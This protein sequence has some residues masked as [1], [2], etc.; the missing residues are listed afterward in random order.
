MIKLVCPVGRRFEGSCT[1]G[2]RLDSFAGEQ[3]QPTGQSTHY[4][5]SE[6]I[7]P[8]SEHRKLFNQNYLALTDFL[9]ELRLCLLRSI[10]DGMRLWRHARQHLH[11][12]RTLR[13]ARPLRTK[14]AHRKDVVVGCVN[15]QSLGSKAPMLCHSIIGSS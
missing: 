2:I 15:A 10:V 1:D 9:F 6:H 13:P 14:S 8:A 7:S 4:E 5:L 12:Q 11:S 3:K